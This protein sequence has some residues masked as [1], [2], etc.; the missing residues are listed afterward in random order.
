ML[1]ADRIVLRKGTVRVLRDLAEPSASFGNEL[2]CV[3]RYAR[4]VL[5]GQA[6]RG[7]FLLADEFIA[8]VGVLTAA[9]DSGVARLEVPHDLSEDAEFEVAPIRAFNRAALRRA[10]DQPPPHVRHPIEIEQRVWQGMPLGAAA[11]ARKDKSEC[12]LKGLLLCC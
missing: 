6:Q 4:L 9:F 8:V 7:C 2:L 10:R 1:D 3:G 11:F 12:L 5:V